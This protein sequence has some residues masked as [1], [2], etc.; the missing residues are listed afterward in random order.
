MGFHGLVGDDEAA[1]YLRVG[2]TLGDQPEYLSFPR[3]EGS[4]RCRGRPIRPGALQGEFANETAGD[5]R[6]EQRLTGRDDPYRVEEPLRGDVLEQEAAGSGA[7]RVVDVLVQ[8]EVVR[9]RMRGLPAPA[10]A[11]C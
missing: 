9:M 6:R 8:V 5:G 1:S 4:E 11:S 2:Q 7:Q 3:G 10:A